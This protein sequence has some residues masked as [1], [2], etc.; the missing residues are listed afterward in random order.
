QR[1]L[2]LNPARAATFFADFACVTLIAQDIGKLP[3]RLVEK[4]KNG[5]WSELT[6]PAFSPVLRKPNHFQ[7]RNQFWEAWVTSKL[8]RGNT[9][10]L[11][12]RDSRQIVKALYVL[13]PD[14]VQVQVADDGSVFY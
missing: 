10:V 12:E 9:F 2:E 13:N 4:D 7:T 1:N 6:N 5:V 3:V 8:R 14:R 11:K